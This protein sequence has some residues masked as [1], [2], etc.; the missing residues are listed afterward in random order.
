MAGNID[1]R[2]PLKRLQEVLKN[3]QAFTGISVQLI[4]RDGSL[5]LAYG[6]PNA[7]CG[8]LKKNVFTA[9]ECFQLHLKAGQ[10]AQRKILIKTNS[11]LLSVFSTYPVNRSLNLTSVRAVSAL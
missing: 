2:I 10:R 4:D 1:T 3:L 11:C 6:E 7:Y 8:I 5:L 9:G